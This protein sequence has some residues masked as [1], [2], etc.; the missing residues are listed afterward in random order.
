[1][2]E[3][4]MPKVDGID[5]VGYCGIPRPVLQEI[6]VDEAIKNGARLRLGIT[7]ESLRDTG[8]SV[9]VTFSDGTHAS[10]DLVVGADGTYSKIRSLAFGDGLKPRFS[11][12][13]C[14][15][16]TTEKPPEMDYSATFY[17]PNVR[18]PNRLTD[19]APIRRRRSF[20]VCS[21]VW[22]CD[23][24]PWHRSLDTRSLQSLKTR[25]AFC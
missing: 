2:G 5:F 10:Y 12:Q 18:T 17:G 4:V 1:L 19:S 21:R 11:G 8:R 24:Y 15:R 9:D 23:K 16:F 3:R 13:G 22:R 25:W 7:A 14:W 20:G 6:L